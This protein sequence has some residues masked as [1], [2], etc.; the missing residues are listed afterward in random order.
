MTAA[1]TLYSRHWRP[2]A[3][4]LCLAASITGRAAEDPRTLIL[5]NWMTSDKSGIIHITAL[6]DGTYEGRIAGGNQP[7]RRDDKNP[8][9]S[10]RNRD[11]L[12]QVLLRGLRYDGDGKWSGGTI[13]DPNS[14]RSYHCNAELLSVG[15]LKLHGFLG[16]PL[17][18][19][20]E[21]WKRYLGTNML[22]P[23]AR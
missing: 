12:D 8:D 6:P 15:E 5:G 3:L 21:L 19:R 10:L 16:F 14:G 23:P 1:N 9:K 18:G 20:N 17:L 11:L 2:V 4:I 13:Y 22:L 7:G